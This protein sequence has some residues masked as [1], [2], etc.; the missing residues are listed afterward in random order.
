MALTTDMCVS[1]LLPRPSK[2]GRNHHDAGWF[3]AFS[4]FHQVL[5]RFRNPR[6][7]H[8]AER[9]GKRAR[10]RVL[11]DQQLGDIGNSRRRCDSLARALNGDVVL[12]AA[13][14]ATT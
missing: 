13:A 11:R 3:R 12:A 7:F 9:I 6:R 14:A 5:C 1:F 2:P 10:V 8:D 4:W